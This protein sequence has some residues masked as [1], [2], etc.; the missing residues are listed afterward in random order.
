VHY[1]WGTGCYFVVWY[2]DQLSE[3]YCTGPRLL[4]RLG[5]LVIVTEVRQSFRAK[6]PGDE[7]HWQSLDLCH[8]Q[9]QCRDTPRP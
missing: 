8:I 6:N 9:P 4:L 1:L 2:F 5:D 7:L 3:P